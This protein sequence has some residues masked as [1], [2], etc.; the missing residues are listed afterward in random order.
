MSTN[1]GGQVH[2]TTKFLIDRSPGG[3]KYDSVHTDGISLRDHFAGLAMAQLL[4]VHGRLYGPGN[5][6]LKGIAFEAYV[7]AD[8]MLVE[9]EKE[10]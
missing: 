9:R 4:D 5:I 10:A 6:D 7:Q 8:A 1:D 3:R 2:P